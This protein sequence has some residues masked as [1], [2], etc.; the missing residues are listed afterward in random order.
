MIPF[1]IFQCQNLF[2]CIKTVLS[3][4][5]QIPREVLEFIAFKKWSHE[6]KCLL[7]H[8]ERNKCSVTHCFIFQCQNLFEWVK[9]VLSLMHKISREFLK[10]ISFKK[11]SHEKMMKSHVCLVQKFVVN[12]ANIWCWKTYFCSRNVAVV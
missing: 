6:N 7:F 11:W 8:D 2:E 12:A 4:V 5:R 10:F 9:N 3:L 1:F